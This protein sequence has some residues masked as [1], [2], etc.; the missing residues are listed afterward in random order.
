MS[1]PSRVVETP[2][3]AEEGYDL[4]EQ[5]GFI[6]RQAAQRH[7]SIF[8][9]IMGNDLTPTQWAVLARLYQ[10]GGSSQNL[11]GRQTAMDAATIKGV[12]DRLLKR[13]LV[14]TKPDPEDGRAS[15]LSPTPLGLERL[16][17]ARAP[18]EDTLVNALADW[19]VDDIHNLTRLLHALRAGVAPSR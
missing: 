19:P 12:V 11:L 14:Q 9:E 16:A 6:M 7:V 5:V 13:K 8:N 10:D 17:A 3:P 2:E 4:A 1:R 15:I 18:Q